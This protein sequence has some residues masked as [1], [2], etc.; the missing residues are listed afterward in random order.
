MLSSCVT[1]IKVDDDVYA[2]YNSLVGDPVYV[3]SE[4][5]AQLIAAQSFP[6][7]DEV[8]IKKGIYVLDRQA[9]LRLVNFVRNKV[10]SKAGTINFVIMMMAD[11]CNL[12]CDYCIEKQYDIIKGICMSKNV[13]DAFWEMVSSEAIKLSPDVEFIFYGGEPLLNLE[14][15]RH[16]LNLQERNLPGSRCSIVTNAVLLNKEI[17]DFLCEHNVSIGIS[18]D[19]PKDITDSHRKYK[20]SDRSVFD[21]VQKSIHYLQMSNADWGL[22]ITITDELINRKSAFYMWLNQ[23]KPVA[24]AFNLLKLSFDASEAQTAIEYYKRAADFMIESHTK[25]LDMNITERDITRKIGYFLE[26]QPVVSDCAAASLNQLTINA[27]GDIHS[28]QCRMHKSNC[29]GSVFDPTS[30]A[31]PFECQEMCD[32]LPIYKESCLKCNALP[33]CGGGCLV[34]GKTLY[35]N[36]QY[37]DH[38][39]CEY[40]KAIAEWI[41]KRLYD[42]AR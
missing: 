9:D 28:C 4:E 37:L 35:N 19:G 33:I 23:I 31:V 26:H 18:V 5:Y 41:Y 11:F 1:S 29:F 7:M 13:I 22:S 21:D 32:N 17:I 12:S 6:E 10:Q 3:S 24:V 38:G 34:Q 36:I 2:V 15:I 27:N 16:F 25:L 20:K 14:G 8:L 30:F 39:Y 42:S 40:A